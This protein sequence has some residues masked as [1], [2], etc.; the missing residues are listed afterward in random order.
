MLELWSLGVCLSSRCAGRGE[1]EGREEGLQVGLESELEFGSKACDLCDRT[2][3]PP[4]SLFL[5]YVV[6][7]SA[8]HAEG[9]G[10][11]LCGK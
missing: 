4:F 2:T 5:E 9:R 3:H 8:S 6:Q 11:R 10:L 1:C 7:S